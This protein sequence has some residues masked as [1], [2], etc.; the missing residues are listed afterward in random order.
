[1]RDATLIRLIAD[2]DARPGGIR[3][4][5][6]EGK[7][8]HPPLIAGA[9]IPEILCETPSGGLRELLARHTQNAARLNVAIPASSRSRHAG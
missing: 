8:G 7:R 9:Y 3:Y 6:H 2:W 1:V 4:P 5:C